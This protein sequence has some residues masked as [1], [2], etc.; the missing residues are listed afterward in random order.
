MSK[1]LCFVLMPFGTKLDAAGAPVHFDLVYRDVIAPAIAAAGLQAIRADEEVTGG[2]IHKPMFERLLLCEYAV[3]DLTTANANVFYELGVRHAVKP[4]TTILI[5]AGS[6]RLPFDVAPLRALPYKVAPSGE[7]V[8]SA[9]AM[10]LLSSRLSSSTT[11]SQDSPVFQLLDWVRPLDVA[12]AKTDT[13]REQADYS[14]AMKD[15]LA[16]A[17]REGL[18][19]LN[20]VQADI[21][22]IRKADAGVVVDL[23]LSYRA[24]SAWQEMIDLVPKMSPP[25]ADTV[26]IQEQLGLAFNRV[27]RRDEAE[28]VLLALIERRGPSSETN[29]ILG[30]VYKD[31]WADALAAGQKLLA[32]GY[33]DKAI[34]AYMTGFETDPRDAYPG[35]N[36]VTLSELREPPDPRGSDI[37]PVVRFAVKR[38]MATSKPDYWDY[39]TLLE[40]AVL[41][42][43]EAAASAALSDALAAV[44]ETWEPETTANNLKMIREARERRGV[45]EPWMS[46]VES[47]LTDRAARPAD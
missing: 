45:A 33:L 22:D 46:E 25:L 14:L 31:R 27:R 17:R 13:F 43:D 32:R 21:G 29:G 5:Y 10:A 16:R 4:Y 2:I 8:D 7:P 18:A 44:R 30:R 9:A 23:Y 28:R 38:K 3:A 19:A 26:M 41:A 1:P 37:V 11:P 24:V 36:A 40:L 12:H 39:A 47:A 20:A 34:N 42:G 15:R 35:I 6:S